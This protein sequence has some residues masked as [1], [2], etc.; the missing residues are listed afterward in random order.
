MTRAHKLR[1]RIILVTLLVA[2]TV[3]VLL[4]THRSQTHPLSLVFERY[5]KVTT[6]DFK[7]DHVGFFW[8]T[9]SSAKTYYFS[10]AGT[11]TFLPDKP[12]RFGIQQADEI[13]ER[14]LA[15]A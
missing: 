4:I 14:A 6:M 10:L 2:V 8:L 11:N 7:V 1:A 5:G 15:A 12:M 13:Q 9:N 3:S